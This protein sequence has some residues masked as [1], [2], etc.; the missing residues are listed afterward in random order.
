M[1]SIPTLLA[2]ALAAFLLIIVPGPNVIY[3]I[4]RGIG[5]GRRAAVASALGIEAG[6]FVH[7]G[8]A[9]LGL[10]ALIASSDTL[11]AL[12]K[13]GGAAYLVVIGIMAI[14]TRYEPVEVVA[15]PRRTGLLRAFLQGAVINILNPKVALFFLA[16][17]P[18]FVDRSSGNTTMQILALGMIFFLIAMVSD[19]V[20]ANASGSIGNW[21]DS[22]EWMSR[23]RNRFSGTVYLVLGAMAALTGS[24]SAR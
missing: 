2:F 8:G 20:Y 23:Q 10:S 9:A 6:M 19:L 13:Y 11:Y 7:I 18:Q 16:F 4:T 5:Q 22:R 15:V 24:N 14:R 1:P 12:V 3:I 21:L 17:L